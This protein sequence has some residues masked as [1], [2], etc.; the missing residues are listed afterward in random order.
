MSDDV[1]IVTGQQ[2]ISGW[3]SVRVTR[4][5]ERMPNDFQ[6]ELTEFFPADGSKIIIQAGAPCQ[7]KLGN[8]LVLTGYIDEYEAKIEAQQHSVSV[9]GRSMS[10]DV[11]DCSAEWNSAQ[12]VNSSA[13][14]I[15]Q[16]LAS[17]YGIPVAQTPNTGNSKPIPQFNLMYGET[18][19]E[20]IERITRYEQLIYYDMPDGSILLSQASTIK[21]GS[22]LVQGVNVQSATVRLSM[23][24]YSNYVC[25]YQSTASFSDGQSLG[26]GQN[27]SMNEF[28][29]AV[30]NTVPRHRQKFIVVESGDDVGYTVTKLRSQWECNRRAGKDYELQVVVDSWRD[31]SGNLWQPNTLVDINIPALK[32]ADRTW[33]IGQVTY[34]R[35]EETGTTATLVLNPPIAFQPEPIILVPQPFA[36][37]TPVPPAISSPDTTGVS[38]TVDQL[39]ASDLTTPIVNTS[40]I[41]LPA[42]SGQ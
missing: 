2:S 8:D 26:S 36:E 29:Q 28:S 1:T 30:D 13:L 20:I 35:N 39:K 32:L 21:A 6:I 19:V 38:S 10:E 33:L 22:A 25:V 7:L 15:I 4:A 17:V 9:S 14:Q 27:N 42:G 16:G 41:P 34:S 40:P 23:K 24:R 11:V 5:I 37:G 18:A 3:T 12:F 31:G